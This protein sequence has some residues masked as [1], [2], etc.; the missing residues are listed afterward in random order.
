MS[1]VSEVGEQSWV[2]V[3]SPLFVW[4]RTGVKHVGVDLHGAGAQVGVPERKQGSVKL[5]REGTMRNGSLSSG[6]PCRFYARTHLFADAV[7]LV[8]DVSVFQLHVQGVAEE[9]QAASA[10][11]HPVS[12][13]QELLPLEPVSRSHGGHQIHLAR[14]K[15]KLFRWTLPGVTLRPVILKGSSGDP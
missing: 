6:G 7:E 14:T 9:S 5:R 10:S 1:E 4:I 11:Q 12:L 8:G 2:G 3:A 15:G 13:H